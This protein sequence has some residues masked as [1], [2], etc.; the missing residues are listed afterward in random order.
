MNAQNSLTFQDQFF[1]CDSTYHGK[2]HKTQKNWITHLWGIGI[3]TIVKKKNFNEELLF[4]FH[5][6]WKS[7][8]NP[9][10]PPMCIACIQIMSFKLCWQTVITL[11]LLQICLWLNSKTKI[12]QDHLLQYICYGNLTCAGNLNSLALQQ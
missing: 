10:K 1:N 2:W 9:N 5:Q 3:Q 8:L 11:N 7:L 6:K 12:R 4:Q